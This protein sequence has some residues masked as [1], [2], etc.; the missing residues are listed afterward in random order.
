MNN[1]PFI[2]KK[3]IF[4]CAVLVVIMYFTMY[5]NQVIDEGIPIVLLS[6]TFVVMGVT[7]FPYIHVAI[8]YPEWLHILLYDLPLI[9]TIIFVSHKKNIY[10]EDFFIVIFISFGCILI[11]LANSKKEY[12]E[13]INSIKT[14]LPIKTRDF[15]FEL[16]KL[17]YSIV[18][19]EIFFRGFLFAQLQNFFGISI[20]LFSAGIFV[21]IHYINRWADR[22]FS[23]KSYLM[24]FLFA[25]VV[26]T[27]YYVT[28]SLIACVICHMIFN[29]SLFLVLIKRVR[30]KEVDLFE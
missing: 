24:Q 14:K 26:G 13:A 29:S 17:I 18:S 30:V 28:S 23:K 2:F 10:N 8:G 7:F 6:T 4:T 3:Q 19:E 1:Q 9:T 15:I 22:I 16:L 12:M 21:F 11:L 20:I 5:F 27:M 25:I